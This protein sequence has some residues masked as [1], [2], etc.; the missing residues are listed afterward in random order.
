MKKTIVLSAV[1]LLL[2]FNSFA[3]PAAKTLKKILELKMPKTVD[4]DMPGT[5]GASVA[6]HPVQKK[7]YA[8]FA[9]NM[10]YPL[11]VFDEKGKRVSDDDLT[12]QFDIR[13]LW[14]N[15]TSKTIQMNGY[16]ESG[17]A[18]YKLDTKGIPTE[19]G[20]LFEGQN[21]P[22]AQSTGTYNSREKAVYFFH[23]ADGTL[24]K[25]GIASGE[26]EKV[27]TLHLGKTKESADFEN[28][29]VAEDYNSAAAYTD[30]PGS[31]IALLNHYDK[32]IELYSLR[33]GY[34]VKEFQLPED[35]VVETMFNFS[36]SNGIY[37][38]FNM[39]ERI[40]KGYK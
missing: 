13:G 21:Q 23:N 34:K 11:A 26:E 37:W 14:Y 15:P 38:L 25:Y 30:I 24:T 6:W 39:E 8:A 28:E 10:G 7:Y 20:E 27:V 40:W 16:A 36:Y 1:S 5:R 31:E 19:T 17:W 22:D 9:G 2:A 18:E 3:Q 33:T 12:T 32:K 29:D 4:D 35:A